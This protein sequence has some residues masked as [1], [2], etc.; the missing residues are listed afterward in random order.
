MPRESSPGLVDAAG[1]HSSLPRGGQ[2]VDHADADADAD[3]DADA[4]QEG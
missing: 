1:R 4:E 2:Q 3:P